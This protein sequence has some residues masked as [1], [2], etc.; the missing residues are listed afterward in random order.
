MATTAPKFGDPRGHVCDALDMCC[1]LGTG[2]GV[3][4]TID[5]RY[6][7]FRGIQVAYIPVQGFLYELGHNAYQDRHPIVKTNGQYPPGI[8]QAGYWINGAFARGFTDEE[9]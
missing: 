2:I 1:H 6:H 5:G 8:I 3:V 4:R 9:L 7:Q